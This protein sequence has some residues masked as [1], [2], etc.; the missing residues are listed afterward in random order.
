MLSLPGRGVAAPPSSSPEELLSPLR[1]P[2]SSLP[3][4]LPGRC[5]F[6][7]PAVLR[8]S[9]APPLPPAA[10]AAAPAGPPPPASSPPGIGA[11]SSTE[12]SSCCCGGGHGPNREPRDA[13]GPAPWPLA[14]EFSC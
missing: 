13:P 14:K 10:A 4:G 9:G 11:P 6:S 7:S 2:L 8:P 5:G 12:K 1:A 3:A